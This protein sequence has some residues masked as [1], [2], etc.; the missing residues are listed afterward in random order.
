MI[1]LVYIHV[2]TPE[3]NALFESQA[4]TIS[5]L[6]KGCT[7]VE[8]ILGSSSQIPVGCGSAV[9]SSTVVV[10]LQVQVCRHVPGYFV[11]LFF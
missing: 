10:Y 1:L 9:V 8:I 6:T 7:R 11:Y 5:A 3:E 4:P 2:Q